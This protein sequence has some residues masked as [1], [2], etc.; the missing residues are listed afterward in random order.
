MFSRAYDVS[1]ICVYDVSTICRHV[2][3]LCTSASNSDVTRP[4][5][6]KPRISLIR[7]SVVPKFSMMVTQNDCKKCFPPSSDP[8]E[9]KNLCHQNSKKKFSSI[10][11][12]GIN[13]II[14]CTHPRR[15]G[16]TERGVRYHKHANDGF[17]IRTNIMENVH[18]SNIP[19]DD[20]ATNGL[21]TQLCVA[22][23]S[24][25]TTDVNEDIFVRNETI[26][27]GQHNSC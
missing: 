12:I 17:R 14:S 23:H 16:N 11:S 5:R 20:V 1:T 18:F 25:G 13:R 7:N 10:Y 24:L 22:T 3:S 6:V 21:A 27:D 8:F 4:I 19:T 26:G 2:T 15:R 9:E